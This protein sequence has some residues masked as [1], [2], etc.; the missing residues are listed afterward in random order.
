MFQNHIY[1]VAENN[2]AVP[3]DRIGFNF[4]YLPDVVNGSFDGLRVNDDLYEY[5]LFAEKTLFDSRLSVDFMLPFYTTSDY[6]PGDLSLVADGPGTD[7]AFGDIAFGFKY[8]L[9]RS[10]QS[11]LSAGLRVEAPSNAEITQPDPT[12]VFY[13]TFEDDVWNFTPYVAF[14]AAPTER[15][16]VQ[17]FVSYRLNTGYLEIP[18]TDFAIR[19]QQLFMADLSAGYWLYRNRC[20]R[21]LTGIVPTV[22]L[23]YTGAFNDE[24]TYSSGTPTTSYVTNVIGKSDVLNLTAGVTTYFNDRMSISTGVAIPLRDNPTPY[25][26]TTSSI[27]TDRRYDWALMANLNYYFGR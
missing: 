11:A 25:P 15:F 1:K 21:G 8:L 13:N 12:S 3:Q 26:A 24:T 9:H 27:G 19:E 14:L 23:H 4:N 10:E 2:S 18:A 22:E 20:K 16:F 6:R 17:S 7:T 5:R